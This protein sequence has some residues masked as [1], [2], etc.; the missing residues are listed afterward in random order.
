MRSASQRH[1]ASVLAGGVA[2]YAFLSMFPALAALVSVYGLVADPED[3]TR[4]M[5]AFAGGLPAAS[6]RRS[7][8]R[9]RSSPPVRPAP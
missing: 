4:Q 2:F 6:G 7:T 3:V 1:Q 5:D 9:W 8:I